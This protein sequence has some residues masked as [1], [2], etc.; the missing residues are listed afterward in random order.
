MNNPSPLIPQGSFEEQKNRGRA[1]A[2]LAIY[3]V[4]AIHG[5]GLMALLMLGC[6]QEKAPPA[7][8]ETQ[9]TNAAPAAAD[10]NAP[11]V[12]TNAPAMAGANSATSSNGAPAETMAPP[13]PPTPPSP[14]PAPPTPPASATDYTVV[15]GDTPSK[16][17]AKNHVTTKDLMQANPG[18]EPTKLKIGQKIHVP[19]A[20]AS[21]SG[22]T[23]AADNAGGSEP[24]YTVKSGDT[25][26]KI[27]TQHGTTVKALR[28]ANSLKTD[29][30]H[31]GDK[32]KIPAKGASAP[33]AST[34]VPS[35]QAG[36]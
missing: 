24:G 32:L 7:T 6:R 2:R 33:P 17:A 12:D 22:G 11:P 10:T 20:G 34:A 29:R 18:L 4:L 19:A 9:A 21:A 25:L 13:A 30:I 5:V 35:T 28:A 14:P 26:S 15:K 27:A 8:D 31:V 3:F 23:A 36:Q 16:I 1:R